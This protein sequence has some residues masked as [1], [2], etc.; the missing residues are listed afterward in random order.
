MDFFAQN[1]KKGSLSKGWHLPGNKNGE[2]SLS[3]LLDF[4]TT[5]VCVREEITV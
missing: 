1:E 3:L 4:F 2:S 5:R